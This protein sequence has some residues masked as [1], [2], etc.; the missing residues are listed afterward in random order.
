M[1]AFLVAVFLVTL[2]ARVMYEKWRDR[3]D[4]D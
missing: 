2:V 1:I 4:R 3:H